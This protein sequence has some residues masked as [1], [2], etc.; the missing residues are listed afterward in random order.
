[1]STDS[2]KEQMNGHIVENQKERR[3]QQKKRTEHRQ[4]RADKTM[5]PVVLR[6]NKPKTDRC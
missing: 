4:S 1:M 3:K 6:Q 5:A 2:L